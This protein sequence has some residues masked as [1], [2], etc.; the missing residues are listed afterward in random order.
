MKVKHCKPFLIE[1]QFNFQMDQTSPQ[2]RSLLEVAM[3]TN[4]FLFRLLYSVSEWR[5]HNSRDRIASREIRFCSPQQVSCREQSCFWKSSQKWICKL[6]KDLQKKNMK[7][8]TR[9]ITN[10]CLW[11]WREKKQSLGHLVVIVVSFELLAFQSLNL[12]AFDFKKRSWKTA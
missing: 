10:S 7:L 3:P 5:H 6:W 4:N 11:H 2:F 1:N 12:S 9:N 8:K